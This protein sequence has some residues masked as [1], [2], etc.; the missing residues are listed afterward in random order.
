MIVAACQLVGRLFPAD[1][2]MVFTG[3]GEK[4]H[5]I[6]LSNFSTRARDINIIQESASKYREIGYNLLN[7]RSGAIVRNIEKT[8]R[9]DPVEAVREIYMR[10]MQ[11]D[12][13]CS[14]VKLTQCFR[15]CG[16]TVLANEIEQHFRPPPPH[17]G[18]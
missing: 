9:D 2:H 17:E 7:D 15:D 14:W 18:T 10:W 4:P 13:D 3:Q 8:A 16:L 12:V 11:T 5:M 1:S 6:N